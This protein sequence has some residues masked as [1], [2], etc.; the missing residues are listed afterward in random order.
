MSTNSPFPVRRR[1][2]LAWLPA[3]GLAAP[4]APPA[5]AGLPDPGAAALLELLDDR[6]PSAAR[7]GRAYLAA[8]P[9]LERDAAALAALILARAP[10]LER[11]A[12]AGTG[13]RCG[14]RSGGA[15][16]PTSSKAAR[17]ASAAGCWPPPRR[18]SARCAPSPAEARTAVLGD[19]VSREQRQVEGRL[20]ARD[21]AAEAQLRARRRA[22]PVALGPRE[23]QASPAAIAATPSAFVCFS[24]FAAR[25]T[26]SPMTVYSSRE[27]WPMVPNRIGPVATAAPI[28]TG[29]RPAA[30]R[31]RS[32]AAPASSAASS[33]RS[34]SAAK[35]RLSRVAPNVA[36]MP[37][38]MYLS[39]LPP[40]AWITGTSRS[41]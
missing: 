29:G 35:V 37:S 12:L 4:A 20:D 22:R 38:P 10:D 13:R 9:T 11:A 34:A 25:F 6:G 16:P 36:R 17:P 3:L 40:C 41:W 1:P 23:R 27:A 5:Q 7:V 26:A 32:Q 18:G 8:A 14:R 21:R 28:L 30:A 19:K 2:F 33:A 15:A 31:S 24:S 39:M